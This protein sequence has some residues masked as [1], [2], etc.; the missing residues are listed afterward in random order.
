MNEQTDKKREGTKVSENLCTLC[1]GKSNSI[2]PASK[3]LEIRRV[4]SHFINNYKE[5]HKCQTLIEWS[6]K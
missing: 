1:T 5:M 4:N 3:A 2:K 6:E